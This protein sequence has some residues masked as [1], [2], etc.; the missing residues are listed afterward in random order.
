LT[1]DRGVDSVEP[2]VVVFAFALI[3]SVRVC[4]NRGVSRRAE[5]CCR[6]LSSVR[7][8]YRLARV[9]AHGWIGA[10]AHSKID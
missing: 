7:R 9:G 10:V 3:V 6:C 8:D 2:Y 1:G 4:T 5:A